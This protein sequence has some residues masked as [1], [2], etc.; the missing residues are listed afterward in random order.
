MVGFGLM[1]A[2]WLLLLSWMMGEVMRDRLMHQPTIAV[3]T[4]PGSELLLPAYTGEMGDWGD[5]GVIGASSSLALS[6]YK[7]SNR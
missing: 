5:C 6:P 7:S 1:E 3:Y 2:A 4:S